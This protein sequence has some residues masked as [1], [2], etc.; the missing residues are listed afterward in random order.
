M[1][2]LL[3]E[4]ASSEGE[5]KT[6]Y[7]PSGL[8]LSEIEGLLQ[9]VLGPEVAVADLAQPAA[10]S[11][12]GA[13]VFWG[14]TRKYLLLPPFPIKE[15]C[16]SS[17]YDA[18]PLR[19]LLQHDFMLALI[20]VRMGAYA[21]GICR[22]EKLVVSKVGTGLIHARH[23]KGGS[24]QHRFERHREKQIEQ[25]LNRVC[26]HVRER[27]EPYARVL[28]YVV[29]GGARTTILSLQ[30]RCPFLSQFDNRTLPPLLTIPAPRKVVLETA[31][32][33]V[34]STSLTEWHDDKEGRDL[35]LMSG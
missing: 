14:S 7:L 19:S 23:K 12:T 10:A 32:G 26:G 9:E 13:V 15:R 35:P 4:L 33:H 3:D 22:D 28:E 34:W 18:E 1:L 8:T 2:R 31:I 6:L 27:L 16:L 5:A 11:E 17:G 21:V 30:K 29:Y 20:L 24:S 25:F